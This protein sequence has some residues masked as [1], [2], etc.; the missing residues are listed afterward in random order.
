[1]LPDSPAGVEAEASKAFSV[2][3]QVGHL[4][5]TPAVLPGIPLP[6][7]SWAS[8]LKGSLHS[9]GK[10]H[11]VGRGRGQ[12]PVVSWPGFSPPASQ[13]ENMGGFRRGWGKR[14][15]QGPPQPL[16][17]PHQLQPAPWRLQSHP[18]PHIFL[19]HRYLLTWKPQLGQMQPARVPGCLPQLI[20]TEG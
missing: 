2:G 11:A 6:R 7:R 5:A 20:Q 3:E 8:G 9:M 4:P 19:T 14:K 12:P 10:W 18:S 13:R 1:M 16:A 17:T 15:K